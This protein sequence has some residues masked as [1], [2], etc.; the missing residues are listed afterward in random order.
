MVDCVSNIIAG[1]INCPGLTSVD[2]VPF[3]EPDAIF[4]TFIYFVKIV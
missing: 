2:C 3:S 4:R 1:F